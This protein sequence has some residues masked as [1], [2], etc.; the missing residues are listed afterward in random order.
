MAASAPVCSKHKEVQDRW[1]KTCKQFYCPECRYTHQGHDKKERRFTIDELCDIND[2]ERKVEAKLTE[3]KDQ[4]EA[5]G[6]Q[7][8]DKKERICQLEQLFKS[9]LSFQYS[10]Q[11]DQIRIAS[12]NTQNA[13][14]YIRH[15]CM[16]RTILKHKFDV[17]A[18]QEV[19]ALG[20]TIRSV[21]ELLHEKE[22]SWRY[23]AVPAH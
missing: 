23:I 11:A 3:L 22:K 5:L 21:C 6:D 16:K 19:G 15:D 20:N 7:H 12:W 4:A 9:R 2:K 1:C 14:I 18:I 10:T 8:K 17:I 13:D